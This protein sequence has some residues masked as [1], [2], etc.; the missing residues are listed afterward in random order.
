MGLTWRPQ[1][2]PAED[3]FK[4][5]ETALAQGSNFWNGGE[6]YGKPERHSCHLLKE[7]FQSHPGDADKVVLSIKGATKPGEMIPDG[8]AK[9]VR[10][11]VEECL[12]VLDGTKSIDIFEC[13]RLDHN[14]SLEE[15]VGTL[16]ELVKEGKIGAIG[17]SE[18]KAST[19]ERAH[20]IHPIAAV[21]VEVSLWSPDILTNGIATTC[22]KLGIPIIAY[23]PLSRGAFAGE[24]IRKN[25]DIPEGDF[26]KHS[27]R[28][29]DDVLEYNNQ[30]VDE[31]EKIAQRKGV[32]KA[33]VAIAWVKAL[34][35]RTITAEDGQQVKLGTII[36]LPGATKPERVIE[37]TTSIQLSDAE[38]EEIEAILKKNPTQGDRYPK[39]GMAHTN[40]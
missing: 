3:S 38:M 31:V 19:I 5:M 17:L 8:S 22:A 23:S 25:A 2:Q 40:M 33:Q 1:P 37:N 14:I 36:P 21:E 28:F 30:I 11:S 29:Q 10:R 15:T 34:S 16:A 20:K 26:R 24:T 35:G 32:T 12:K 39:A 18:V 9:N 13:A 6:L 7:Y 27:P 4:A